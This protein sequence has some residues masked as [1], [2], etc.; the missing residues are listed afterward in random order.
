[1]VPN[2]LQC[3]NSNKLGLLGAIFLVI[4][5]LTLLML[6]NRIVRI[7]FW[8][9]FSYAKHDTCGWVHVFLRCKY[10]RCK[11]NN[12]KLNVLLCIWCMHTWYEKYKMTCY[13]KKNVWPTM[14]K[15][16]HEKSWRQEKQ[17]SKLIWFFI[18]FFLIF[19]FGRVTLSRS[20]FIQQTFFHKNFFFLSFSTWYFF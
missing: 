1:M 19:T 3:S 4:S 9:K 16:M 17:V 5:S 18:H 14:T 10:A 8:K 6:S 11:C 15:C 20:S 2:P 7:F 12:E 13:V